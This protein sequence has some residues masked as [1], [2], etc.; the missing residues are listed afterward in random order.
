[1]ANEDR[2]R[3]VDRQVIAAL[4]PDDVTIRRVVAV[5]LAEE[6]REHGAELTITGTGSSI[7]VERAD[8]KRWFFG[9]EPDPEASRGS[10]VIAIPNP[11]M[12]R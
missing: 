12:S 5:G 7:I 6:G 3:D 10:Y 9:P 2:L 11:E 4:A 8:G 1:M